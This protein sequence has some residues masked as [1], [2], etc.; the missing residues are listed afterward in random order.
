MRTDRRIRALA[1]FVFA[2]AV[3]ASAS[4]VAAQPLDTPASLAE[5]EQID[6][7]MGVLD[8]PVW[9]PVWFNRDHAPG[10]LSASPFYKQQPPGAQEDFR[11][12][13][14]PPTPV[15]LPTP[16]REPDRLEPVPDSDPEPEIVTPAPSPNSPDPGPIIIDDICSELVVLC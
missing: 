2:S 7:A 11:V 10:A 6:A 9:K 1:F 4:P 15:A 3:A 8:G 12:P 16:P 13:T 5:H 14:S